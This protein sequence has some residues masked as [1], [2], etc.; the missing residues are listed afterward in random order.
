MKRSCLRSAQWATRGQ[1][2]RGEETRISRLP[3]RR[4]PRKS[5]SSFAAAPRAEKGGEELRVGEGGGP[6]AGESFPDIRLAAEVA[7]RVVEAVRGHG[8]PPGCERAHVERLL[9]GDG[10][11]RAWASKDSAAV[12]STLDLYIINIGR[13]AWPPGFRGASDPPFPKEGAVA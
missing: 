11:A 2:S 1:T 3:K 5:S 7:G 13:G 12:A 8:Y 10:S 9:E 6:F 4:R